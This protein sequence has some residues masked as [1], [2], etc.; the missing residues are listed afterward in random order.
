MALFIL[1]FYVRIG[2]W[3]E[4]I[5]I[6]FHDTARYNAN[7]FIVRQYH[8]IMP[9]SLS[10]RIFIEALAVDVLVGAYHSER[11]APQRVIMDLDIGFDLTRAIET[12]QLSD[13][14]DY[15]ELISSL[16]ATIR[17]TRYVLL[18]T[19]ADAICRHCI[20][21]FHAS[22]VRIRLYK[23]DILEHVGRVGIEIT[24]YTHDYPVTHYD[25]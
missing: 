16:R 7:G 2:C 3:F 10:D 6:S 8:L 24:R 22:S 19:L 11:L 14:L 5:P 18:E 12:D 20:H 25:C 15:A 9:L 1:I 21:C 23:P 4:L 13:T 17:Q